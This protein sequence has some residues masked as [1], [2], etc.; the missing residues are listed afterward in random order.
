MPCRLAAGCHALMIV[1]LIVLGVIYPLGIVY[2]IGVAAV[3]LLLI[4][5]HALVRPDDLSRVNVA[6]FQVNIVISIGLLVVA[7]IDLLVRQIRARLMIPSIP[8]K[9]TERRREPAVGMT[10]WPAERTEKR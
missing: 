10:G 6:F 8:T 3:G 9:I 2:F 1:P 7:V 4:Y 5:E